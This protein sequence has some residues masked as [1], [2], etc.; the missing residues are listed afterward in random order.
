MDQDIESSRAP[1]CEQQ[2]EVIM[3]ARGNEGQE[4]IQL[5]LEQLADVMVNVEGRVNEIIADLR[6][7]PFLA[8]IMNDVDEEIAAQPDDEGIDISPIDDIELDV[9]P[10]DYELEVENYQW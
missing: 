6:E 9:E 4:T 5:N 2:I 1:V 10:F 8:G 7:D 3:P